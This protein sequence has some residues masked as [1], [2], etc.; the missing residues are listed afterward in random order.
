MKATS[1]WVGW[2]G[3]LA[4]CIGGWFLL[5]FVKDLLFGPDFPHEL[6][7]KDAYVFGRV[8]AEDEGDGAQAMAV[9]TSVLSA[10]ERDVPD[11]FDGGG[12]RADFIEGCA[13]NGMSK[14]DFGDSYRLAVHDWME[15]TAAP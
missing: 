10:L 1:N 14:Y 3:F 7:Q 2:V 5:G 15:D 9:C 6:S 11:A 8:I 4:L 12:T 13:G